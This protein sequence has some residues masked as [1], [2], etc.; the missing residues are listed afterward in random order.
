MSDAPAE[1]PVERARQILTSAYS[2]SIF[3]KALVAVL[4]LLA[5]S[6][7]S[8]GL[9]NAGSLANQPLAGKIKPITLN[10]DG[11]EGNLKKKDFDTLNSGKRVLLNRGLKGSGGRGT[12]VQDI[13]ADPQT[14]LKAV[15]TFDRYAGRLA[16]CSYS[17]VYGRTQNRMK[18]TENI[19]VHMKLAGGVKTF[20]CY[21]DHTVTPSKGLV[22]WELDPE[23]T[24]DFVDVQGQWYVAKHPTKQGWSRVWYSAEVALPPWLPGP[25]VVQLCKTSGAKALS[26]VKKEAEASS[27]SKWGRARG[28]FPMPRAGLRPRRWKR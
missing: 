6:R 8:A 23:K 20:N 14:V 25:I 7:I 9:L 16:Q 26:F 28:G 2:S 3:G 5:G 15:T 10:G 17:T 24:S 1:G 27:S 11:W 13:Q 22:T 4:V 21:Y 12:A 18:G 19:K